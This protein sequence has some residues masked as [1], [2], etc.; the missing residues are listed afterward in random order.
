MSYKDNDGNIV[1]PT[2]VGES[3]GS[4]R[5]R[6]LIA[7]AQGANGIATR[8]RKNPDGVEILLKTRAGNPDITTTKP[9][10]TYCTEKTK[11][12]DYGFVDTKHAPSGIGDETSGK[13]QILVGDDGAV[14]GDA[15]H[16][17]DTH[18]WKDRFRV[19][20]SSTV[21]GISANDYGL[22][23]NYSGLMRRVMQVVHGTSEEIKSVVH[24]E[25]DGP[26]KV[27]EQTDSFSCY[28]SRSDG[29]FIDS[30][31]VRWIIEVSAT[32]VLPEPKQVLCASDWWDRR[33]DHLCLLLHTDSKCRYVK[34]GKS[35]RSIN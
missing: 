7:N 22:P 3:Q 34:Q 23:S 27:T 10:D 11:L 2:R 13:L 16:L 18:A 4:A 12:Q 30:F 1:F 17:G 15:A 9:A 19:G 33:K 25:S 26:C 29:M 28:F 6:T 8:T 35:C 20:T 32:G 14:I 31:G 24:T 21:D 5:E